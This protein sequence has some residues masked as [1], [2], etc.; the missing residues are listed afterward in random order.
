MSKNVSRKRI[1][2]KTKLVLEYLQ[3]NGSITSWEAIE[4][5]S[6]TRLSAIIYNLRKHY[7]I[8]SVDSMCVDRYGNQQKFTK[9]TYIGLR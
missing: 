9:Y 1:T 6:A 5:Y 4:R 8:D 3:N 2:N 7:L